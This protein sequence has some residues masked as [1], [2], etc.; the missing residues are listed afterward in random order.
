[1]AIRSACAVRLIPA[2]AGKTVTF[3]HLWTPPPAHP[4]VCGEN[5]RV[6]PTICSV[7]GSSPRVRGKPER[8]SPVRNPGRLIPACAGKTPRQRRLRIGMRAHPR[9][10]GENCRVSPVRPRRVGSSPRVRGK[11]RHAR[12]RGVRGGLIPA[13]AGK[14]RRSYC[15]DS[16]A[17]AHPRVCG[18]NFAP[19]YTGTPR[20]G[21]SPRVRGKRRRRRRRPPTGRLI[22]ACAGKTR[23]GRG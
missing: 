14:T 10:C 15:T 4:R 7:P 11:H 5:H 23:S 18:E 1:M 13:C 12:G 20:P 21:S 9:V 6:A 2:C 3:C 22:P 17:E 16:P 19:V 8:A